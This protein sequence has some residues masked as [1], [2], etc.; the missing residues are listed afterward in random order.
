MGKPTRPSKPRKDDEFREERRRQRA[1]QREDDEYALYA[2]DSWGNDDLGWEG[3]EKS[4]RARR[5]GHMGR[6]RRRH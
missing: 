4:V 2:E 5:S 1:Q 3:G 6:N